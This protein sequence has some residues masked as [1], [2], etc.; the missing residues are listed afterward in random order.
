VQEGTVELADPRACHAE[1]DT[2]RLTRVK[3]E[4]EPLTPEDFSDPGPDVAPWVLMAP[5]ELIDDH[6]PARR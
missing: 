4:V 3:V 6:T 2:L 1:L 5:G